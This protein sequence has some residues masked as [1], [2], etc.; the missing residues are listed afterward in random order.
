MIYAHVLNHGPSG[1]QS[2]IDGIWPHV[3]DE[4]EIKIPLRAK[5]STSMQRDDILRIMANAI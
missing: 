4:M 2:S 1:V 5:K 3:E